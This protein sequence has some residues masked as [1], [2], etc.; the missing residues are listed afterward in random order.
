MCQDDAPAPEACAM[1]TQ[2]GIAQVVLD[3]LVEHVRFA[4][5]QVGTCCQLEERVGPL[6]VAR[7]G[8][9]PVVSNYTQS[10][11]LSATGM[12]NR[13]GGDIE[14]PALH[15]PTLGQFDHATFAPALILRYAMDNHD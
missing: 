10:V 9:Q 15:R 6:G 1:L 2:R 8:D 12:H 5:E 3:G 13:Y 7:V 11:R 14:R 4:D